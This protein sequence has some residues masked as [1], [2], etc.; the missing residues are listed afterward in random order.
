MLPA[1][2]LSCAIELRWYRLAS[3]WVTAAAGPDQDHDLAVRNLQAEIVDR[4]GAARV[5]L[6]HVLKDDHGDPSGESHPSWAEAR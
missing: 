1:S 2:G 5:A 3:A 4:D 6:R